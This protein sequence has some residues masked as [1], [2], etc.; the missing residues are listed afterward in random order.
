MSLVNQDGIGF[1]SPYYIDK[2]VR[3]DEGTFDTATA[4][5]VGGFLKRTSIAHGFTRPVFTDLL[6]SVDGTTWIDGGS[7]NPG[8]SNVYTISYSDS[9]NNYI[10][11]TKTTGTLYYILISFWITDYDDTNPDVAS[12]FPEN[13]T[14]LFDS[15]ENYQ[16]ILDYGTK[17]MTGSSTVDTPFTNPQPDNK[18]NSRSFFEAFSGQV[19]PE[20]FG[21]VTNPFLYDATNQAELVSYTSETDLTNMIIVPVGAGLQARRVWYR[22]YADTAGTP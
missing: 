22:V 14:I 9:T 18:P 21:G 5:T 7:G 6:W 11:T 10:L 8:T 1:A 12:Y 2:I 20:N 4:T 3:V 19:W 17:T 13:T 16:K 15:R